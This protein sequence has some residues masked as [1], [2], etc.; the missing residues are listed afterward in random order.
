MRIIC[1]SNH[2]LVQE[3]NYWQQLE[4]VLAAG[5]DA[6][7]LRE[8]T[9][10]PQEYASYA[11]KA[12]ILCQ[13]Y[14]TPCLLHSFSNIAKELGAKNFHCSL[15]YLENHPSLKKDFTT[16]GVSLHTPE[17][18]KKAAALG[19][20]YLLAGHIFPTTCKPDSS[21]IGIATL[22]AICAATTLPVYALGG[23]TPQ[24]VGQLQGLPL[25]GIALMSG[26]MTCRDAKNYKQQLLKNL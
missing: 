23:I 17:E 24:T 25:A 14:K 7:I 9:L 6:L 11:L 10:T 4:K 21:P 12:L 1:I 18:A 19:A 20:S 13:R 2:S 3:N 16:L 22:Q 5:V 26:L 8:K 15:A